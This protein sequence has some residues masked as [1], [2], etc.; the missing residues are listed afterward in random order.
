VAV[1]AEVFSTSLRTPQLRFDAEFFRPERIE[2]GCVAEAFPRKI[3]LGSLCSKLTQGP[4][5]TFV[6]SGIPCLNGKNIY[7]GT[8]TSGEPNYVSEEEYNRFAAYQLREGDIVITLKHATKIGRAWV[9]EKPGRMI[10]SRNVGLIRLKGTSPVNTASVLFYI[11][12]SVGQLQLDRFATGGTSGQITLPISYLKTLWIPRFT[13]AAQ[14][15]LAG[16]LLDYM[17]LK[18]KAEDLY[19]SARLMLEADLGLDNVLLSYPVGYE[20]RFSEIRAA[21]RFDGEYFKPSFRQIVDCVFRYRHGYEPLLRHVQEIR[22]NVDPRRFPDELFRYVEL[23]DINASLGLITSAAEVVGRDAP[24]R[25]RRR[26]A[27]DDVLIS[28]VVGSIDKA[29]LVGEKFEDALASTGFFQFRSATYDPRYLLVLLRCKAIRMQLE[30]EATGGILSAVSQRRLRYVIIPQVPQDIQ[31]A[32]AER[33]GESH[34][35]YRK[36]EL[37]LEKAKR[38]V[39]EMIEQETAA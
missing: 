19:E 2:A 16:Y 26:I 12:S 1:W 14:Q 13:R 10:F 7:F 3:R 18:R 8:A 21:R 5:P 36:A 28:A 29:A 25:A 23:A 17:K 4:N 20:A 27:K 30:R 33:V 32:I 24:S 9:I 37:L 11:W 6:A 39:E 31:E 38:R 15:E 22:P 34:S 35:T